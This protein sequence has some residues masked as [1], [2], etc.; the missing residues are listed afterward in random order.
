M[1]PATLGQFF[2]LHQNIFLKFI[3]KPFSFWFCCDII[4]TQ[5]GAILRDSVTGKKVF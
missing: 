4:K 2:N 1:S 3:K 5:A